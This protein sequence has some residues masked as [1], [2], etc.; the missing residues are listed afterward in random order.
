MSVIKEDW[1][2]DVEDEEVF[3]DAAVCADEDNEEEER[4]RSKSRLL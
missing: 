4:P 3:G 1:K 2:I